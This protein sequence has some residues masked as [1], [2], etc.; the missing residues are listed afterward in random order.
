MFITLV[1]QENEIDVKNL[2]S[3][4]LIKPK[5]QQIELIL[6]SFVI[7]INEL[8]EIKKKVIFAKGNHKM[9]I[10]KGKYTKINEKTF[11]DLIDQLQN[12]YVIY[13]HIYQ[14]KSEKQ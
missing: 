11:M 2:L 4:G 5:R 9:V 14:E 8:V 12:H 3:C 10:K 13:D 7:T 6:D 1:Y